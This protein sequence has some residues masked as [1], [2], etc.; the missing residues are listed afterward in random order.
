MT[1]RL[2]GTGSAAQL[3]RNQVQM[4]TLS[5]K[6]HSAVGSTKARVRLQLGNSLA[7]L[8]RPVLTKAWYTK[9]P[10]SPKNN[11]AAL[12]LRTA[13]QGQRPPNRPGNLGGL[14]SGRVR[15]ANPAGARDCFGTT[16]RRDAERR[17]TSDFVL[18][19][20]VFERGIVHLHNGMEKAI[21]MA[22]GSPERASVRVVHCQDAPV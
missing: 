11:G 8:T 2:R 14:I 15:R 3:M 10:S 12:L 17:V 7:R 18:G 22:D 16:V 21:D 13:P 4:A 6:V 19:L 5:A 20:R 1:L 9:A